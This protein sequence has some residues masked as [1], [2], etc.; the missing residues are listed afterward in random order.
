MYGPSVENCFE[1]TAENIQL[2][3]QTAVNCNVPRYQFICNLTTDKNVHFSQPGRS[4]L[5][6][7]KILTFSTEGGYKIN[8]E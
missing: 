1:V 2:C 7:I 6:K 3:F 8:V 4:F 5:I